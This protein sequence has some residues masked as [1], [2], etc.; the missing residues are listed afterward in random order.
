MNVIMD[1]ILIEEYRGELLE[2]VH[3]GY[4]CC[5]NEDGQVVYSIG[6]PG[7]VTF[8]RSSA[9]PIQAIPLIKRGIDTKYNLSNKEITVMTGSH[10]AEP[11]HVTALESIMDKVK[12]DEDELI[13]LPTYPLSMNAKE[14]ILRNGGEKRRIYHNC[15]GKHMGILTLCTDM[16][17]DKREYWNINSPAQQE[18]LSH[19]S[20]MSEYPREQIKIGTDGCGVPVFAMPMKNLA[21]AYMKMACPDTI[22]DE[23]T[24]DAV[25]KL[26]KLMNENYEMVSGTDLICSLLLM[27]DNIVAKGGAKGVYCFG[28]R[29]ERLGFSIKI[30]DGSEEEWPLIVAS[31]LEQINY[32]NKDTIDRLKRVFPRVIVN[33]NNKEVGESIVRFKL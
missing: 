5:V 2:C 3:R 27:D 23:I 6:D 25:I 18:I 17:C 26:T 24:R 9:K 28:L 15:S 12:I 20:M 30:I 16:N 31:I 4:I 11:F 14:E 33:D 32:K 10:R 13:C 8:M 29:D 1:E 7:F 22:G 19:I 21:M